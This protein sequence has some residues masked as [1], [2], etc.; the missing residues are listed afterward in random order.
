MRRIMF[1]IVAAVAL[2]TA[3]LTFGWGSPGEA[4]EPAQ[5]TGQGSGQGSKLSDDLPGM[6]NQ[7]KEFV[8]TA[9]GLLEPLIDASRLG[10]E[11]ADDAKVKALSEDMAKAYPDLLARLKDAAKSSG[12]SLADKPDPHG[13]HRVQRLRDSGDEFDLAYLIEQHGL[14]EKLIAIYGM[15]VKAGKAEALK[16]HAEDGRALLQ[17]NFERIGELRKSLEKERTTPGR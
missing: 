12:L 2:A 8:K 6:G 7:D 11:K 14:H 1:A 13:V 4:A 9:S 10:A 16:A 5:G 17:K 3:G 15:E